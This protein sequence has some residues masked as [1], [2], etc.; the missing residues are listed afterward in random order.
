MRKA[1]Y[2][3]AC[4]MWP[5]RTEFIVN[6]LLECRA[7]TEALTAA[8]AVEVFR[9][10][11]V[12]DAGN[13]SRKDLGAARNKL[14]KTHHP[15][16][17]GDLQAMQEINAAYDTLTLGEVWSADARKK[18]DDQDDIWFS[19]KIGVEMTGNDDAEDDVTASEFKQ[20]QD[21]S[22][23]RKAYFA[24]DPMGEPPF[25]LDPFWGGPIK[26]KYVRSSK[27][28][29]GMQ[30]EQQRR[31][32]PVDFVPTENWLRYMY[33]WKDDFKVQVGR[34][35]YRFTD[36]RP[37][38]KGK[39]YHGFFVVRLTPSGDES[40]EKSLQ[41]YGFRLVVG[42]SARKAD[43][44]MAL[45]TYDS[46][47]TEFGKDSKTTW[48][49]YLLDI[50]P[51]LTREDV[52]GIL[53]EKWPR[54][55][56]KYV[57]EELYTVETMRLRWHKLD[58]DPNLRILSAGSRVPFKWP[59][60]ICAIA[61]KKLS[62]AVVF[63]QEVYNAVAYWLR[64]LLQGKHTANQVNTAFQEA[65]DRG[66]P[67]G[68]YV[69][70]TKDSRAAYVPADQKIELPYWTPQYAQRQEILSVEDY[71]S[72][73]DASLQHELVHAAQFKK[74]GERWLRDMPHTHKEVTL[75]QYYNSP[76]EIMAHAKPMSA[77]LKFMPKLRRGLVPPEMAKHLDKKSVQRFYK[78][79]AQYDTQSKGT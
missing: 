32:S 67:I 28:R 11:G 55:N 53:L 1:E 22:F 59:K 51:S 69:R 60:H 6:T 38:S 9:K 7:L 20:F 4:W 24:D 23:D 18:R 41:A 37:A 46:L 45:P 77:A 36:I 31:K 68:R 16:K 75:N 8:Q 17:G 21:G 70:F 49:A 63:D 35:T 40:V 26:E 39:G 78:Y 15:D 71:K 56:P 54:L 27:Y 29:E 2:I 65:I 76:H 10:H 50:F 42:T 25:S 64:E 73:L 52:L 44:E 43:L 62:E 33:F 61:A 19:P 12:L 30:A 74:G 57:D 14:S 13:L 58:F 72:E 3:V 66:H 5:S 34:A 79:A 48:A 47:I